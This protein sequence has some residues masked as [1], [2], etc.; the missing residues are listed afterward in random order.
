M[1]WS[2]NRSFPAPF[3]ARAR[4]IWL[5]TPPTPMRIIVERPRAAWSNPGTPS[6]AVVTASS[7]FLLLRGLLRQTTGVLLDVEK[8]FLMLY[9]SF[10]ID[11]HRK[12]VMGEETKPPV[13]GAD[14]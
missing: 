3:R 5:P 4:A 6:C 14:P 13:T 9:H 2:R 1:S 10:A 11:G 7:P 8:V 12:R